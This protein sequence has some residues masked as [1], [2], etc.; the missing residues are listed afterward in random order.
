MSWMNVARVAKVL[1]ILLF[2][3][4][5]LVVSCNGTPLIEASGVDMITGD[6]KPAGD[7]PFAGMGDQTGSVSTPDTEASSQT[8]VSKS[9][10]INAS[11]LWAPA[12]LALI[13]IALLV[14]FVLRPA[15]RAA[16]SAFIATLA[17][18]A[19]LGGGMGWTTYAFKN[20][21]KQAMAE[22]SG[23]APAGAMGD[24]A[25]GDDFGRSM[26]SMMATAIKMEIKPGFWLT[27]AL[28]AMG[29]GSAWMAAKGRAFPG[30]KE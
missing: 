8:D 24:T 12:G 29:G 14:G 2:F 1:A 30:Q 17:A 19:V 7:S 26:A 25:T 9:E 5:W 22:Q 11:R 3:M 21:M 13:V 4:P 23:G 27:L 18:I 10:G 16:M 28:L 15:K 6:M 20:E